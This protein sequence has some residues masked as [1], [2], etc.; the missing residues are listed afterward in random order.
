V[1]Q[2]ETN[3]TPFPVGN[4]ARLPAVR[5]AA[6][7]PAFM[8]YRLVPLLLLVM[9]A[10]ACGKEVGDSCVIATDCSPNGDRICDTLSK[11]G[12]CTV[13]GCDYT[14]CPDE[15]VCVQFFT[16]SFANRSCD[17]VCDSVY[18]PASPICQ[19]PVAP[20]VQCSLDELC[21]IS[22]DP[23]DP[24]VAGKCVPRSSEVRYCMRK[25][26]SDGDCRDGYECRDVAQ[27]KTDGG[28]PA[29]APGQAIDPQG[30]V[31]DPNQTQKD[32]DGLPEPKVVASHV[33][34]F[35]AVAPATP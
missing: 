13:R 11:E 4:P 33:Q 20:N 9:V 12:Y 16:G 26:N 21:A 30:Q 32:A 14:T 6:R 35:C 27:M 28:E 31:V 17:P 29:L 18:D 25:C 8:G 3:E 1:S 7:M 24:Q 5:T 19:A 23:D 22:S 10:G 34:K 2:H 15:A